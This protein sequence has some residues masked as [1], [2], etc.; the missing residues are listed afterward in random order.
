MA[1]IKVKNNEGK[2]VEIPTIKGNDGKTPEKGVDYF[3]PEDIAGLNIPKKISDLEN[4]SDFIDR[5]KLQEYDTELKKEVVLAAEIR[6]IEIV[7][8]YPEV[9]ESGVLYLKVVQ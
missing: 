4:D 9:E 3:T 1:I 5:K 6:K 8:E 7:D 2:F